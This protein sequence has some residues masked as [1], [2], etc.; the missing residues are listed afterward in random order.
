MK[1]ENKKAEIL[2]MKVTKEVYL[3]MIGEA[4]HRSNNERDVFELKQELSEIGKW[5]DWAEKELNK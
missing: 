1:K 2:P 4:I 3:S 5:I